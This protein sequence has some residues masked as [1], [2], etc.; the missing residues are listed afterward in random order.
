MDY[1][2]LPSQEIERLA[3]TI[4]PGAWAIEPERPLS[5]LLG[6][7]VA[8]CLFDPQSRVGGLNHF[9]L[10][11]IRRGSNDDVDSLLSGSYAME[12]LLNAL[13]QRGA[14][15]VRLQAKAFGGG[16][17]INTSGPL[18]S[19]GLRNAEFTKEWLGREGIPLLASDFLGPWSRKV[20]FLPATGDVF[21]RR[22]V[23]N[24]ATAEVITREEQS[25]ATTLVQ[26]PGA[27][28]KKIELF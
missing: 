11:T 22:M 4:H 17:I 10:P 8:V 5:T 13:L 7:C 1:S 16:T 24:M 19:I 15:K 21:C 27:T 14:K 18:M 3:R 9:M 28:D 26:K 25:Y 23:T 6:S 2:K 20:L 12:A